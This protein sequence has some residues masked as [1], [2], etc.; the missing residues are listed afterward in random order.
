MT[1]DEFEFLLFDRIEKIKSINEQYDLLNNAYISFSG[2]KDST[3]LHYLID[4]ALP[5]NNIPR[6]YANTGIEY[7]MVR[8]F[9]ERERERDCRIIILNQTRN[10]KKTLEEYGYPFK[11]KEHSLRVEQYHKGKNAN[12]L[13]K[14]ISGVDEKRGQLTKHKCPNILKYQFSSDFKLN[15]SN[16]CCY[17]LKK[18][19][20][21]KWAK[22]NNKKIVI[23]EMSSL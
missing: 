21:K 7:Q 14:Y 18:D 3:V 9:V 8:K 16:L 15:V 17:K 11:S 19:L 5:N 1:D 12:Y 13:K 4:M 6:I 20:M 2:G 23:T 10:I 22:E